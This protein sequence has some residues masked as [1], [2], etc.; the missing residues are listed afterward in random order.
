MS[1]NW[2]IINYENGK[3]NHSRNLVSLK[4]DNTEI[5]NQN[6][7]ANIFNNYFLSIAESLNSGNNKQTNTKE[8]N[9]INYL[10]NSFHQP[11]PKMTW[12]NASTHEIEKNIK[13]LKSK[14]TGGYDE[15]STRILKLSTPYII[16]PLT[17]ICNAIL[18]TGTFPDR[19]KY[20]IIKPIF[21]KG[22]DQDITNYRPIYLLTSFSKVTEK[23]IYA[24]LFNHITTNSTLVNEQYGFRTQYSTELATFSFINNILT[25]MNNNLNTGG[26]FC[27]LQK[28]FDCVNHEI[29][30][31]KLELCSIQGKFK[32]LMQSY[33]TGRYQKV[34]LNT[35]TT[36][37]SSSKWKL[38]KN[39]VPQGS[40]LGPLLFFI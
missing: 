37:N 19:F 28:A 17:Y 38:I 1:T 31:N 2:K 14:N 8:P 21:K 22:D 32:T 5:T 26:I 15:I 16:S 23:L 36:S 29:L 7:V 27:D 18:N 34:S 13:S 40:I 33:L 12:H 35:N 25:A 24:R 30:L 9:P 39:G 3:P 6:T 4:I 10:I 20:A 11:F